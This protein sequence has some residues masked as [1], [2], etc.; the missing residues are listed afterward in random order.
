MN[1][2]RKAFAVTTSFFLLT[3]IVVL[4]SRAVQAEFVPDPSRPPVVTLGTGTRFTP[5]P[6]K[7]VLTESTGAGSR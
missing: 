4:T 6:G 3:T 2:V 5:P 7:G 1:T